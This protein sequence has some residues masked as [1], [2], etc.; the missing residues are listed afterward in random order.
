MGSWRVGLSW[1]TRFLVLAD[2]LRQAWTVIIALAEDDVLT[3]AAA[4]ARGIG[5]REQRCG[6]P[7]MVD[8][9]SRAADEGPRSACAT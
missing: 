4:R 7:S 5:S 2:V 6:A 9:D 1:P 8:G 3:E